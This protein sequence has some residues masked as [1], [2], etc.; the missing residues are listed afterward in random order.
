MA[1]AD[2]R[3]GV[4]VDVRPVASRRSNRLAILGVVA[5]GASLL[6]IVAVGRLGS[7]QSSPAFVPPAPSVVQPSGV[8]PSAA[9][10]SPPTVGPAP[11]RPSAAPGDERFIAPLFGFEVDPDASIVGAPIPEDDGRVVVFRYGAG[12]AGLTV[13]DGV[14]A[15]GVGTPGQGARVFGS[16]AT[17]RVFGDSL[18]ALEADFR[19]RSPDRIVAAVSTTV[20]G[21]PA[22]VLAVESFPPQLRAVAL[23]VPNGRAF[24]IA[25]WGFSAFY[26]GNIAE[27]AK[28]GLLGFL[29]RLHF[30]DP[31][32]YVNGD[33]GFEAAAPD[34]SDVHETAGDAATGAGEVMFRDASAAA[35]AGP[36]ASITV[37]VGTAVN[38]VWISPS[39]NGGRTASYERVWAPTL[40][41]AVGQY[42][43]AVGR[44]EGVAAATLGGESAVLIDRPGLLGAALIAV[45]GG[46]VYI[47][48]T[49]GP[50][51]GTRASPFDEFVASVRFL[52]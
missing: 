19:H 7:S 36:P 10:T 6:G 3:L 18:A 22:R 16:N 44:F 45:H 39:A 43:T 26:P 15:V 29:E 34:G 14:V 51:A 1:A 30:T 17:V 50:T 9:S 41:E 38:P 40:D 31:R 28:D 35:S 2:E 32:R 25:S 48:T 23:V 8:A 42:E 4:E 49:V 11:A 24:V 21:V 37:Q 12:A 27:A 13:P 33:L 47:V 5:I 46:R 52:E 20:D